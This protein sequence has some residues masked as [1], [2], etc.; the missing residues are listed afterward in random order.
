ML[1]HASDSMRVVVLH[2]NYWRLLVLRPVRRVVVRMEVTSE[3]RRLKTVIL[4]EHADGGPKG[5]PV[6]RVVHV[7]DGTR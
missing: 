7:A 6:K 2:A 4:F 3:Q 5:R 1:D